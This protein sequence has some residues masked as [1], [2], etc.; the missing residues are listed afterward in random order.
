MKIQVSIAIC[1]LCS[2]SL[3][4]QIQVEADSFIVETKF[5]YE[6][7]E[8]K[9]TDNKRAVSQR[10][11]NNKNLLVRKVNFS[12]ETLQPEGIVYY[13]Y[14][15]A[16]N[17]FREY[18][19]PQNKLTQYVSCTYKGDNLMIYDSVKVNPTNSSYQVK[20]KYKPQISTQ[21]HYAGENK[22]IKTIKTNLSEGNIISERIDYT[23][24]SDTN[25]ITK[26]YTYTDTKLTKKSETIHLK[27][28]SIIYRNYTYQYKDDALNSME[29]LDKEKL[30]LKTNYKYYSNGNLRTA[31]TTNGNKEYLEIVLFEYRLAELI[32]PSREIP[33]TP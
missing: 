3:F 33:K 10:T 9:A 1:F 13:H 24:S 11:F 25:S 19:N 27:S 6:I 18:I 7:I 31:V 12:P 8:G 22:L 17:I 14:K 16:K 4:A 21:K 26:N 30:L 32:I 28:G 5:M 29:V 20:Y 15:G 23:S 2:A